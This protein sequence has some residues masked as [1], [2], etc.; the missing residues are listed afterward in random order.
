MLVLKTITSPSLF[1]KTL[2][3]DEID[4]GIGGRVADAV[5]M[6]LKRLAKT[7]QV[8]C[9]THQLQIARHAD[10]HFMVSKDIVGGRTTT[11]IAELDERGRI[12]ELARMIGG[13]EVTAS[14]R[15]HAKELIKSLAVETV[16]SES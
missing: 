6:R 14:A 1:P 10:A 13:S 3:F 16:A 12:E 2:I 15:K 4:V 7:N 9:V 11:K 5:G 8:L